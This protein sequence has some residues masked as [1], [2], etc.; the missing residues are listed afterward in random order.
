M[1]KI[2][3]LKLYREN[4]SLFRAGLLFA[5]FATAFMVAITSDYMQDGPI[6]QFSATLSHIAVGI[7]RLWEPVAT[8]TG[9]VVSS[10]RFSIRIVNGCNG[11]EVT[12]LLI[13]AILATPVPWKKRVAGIAIGSALIYVLNLFRIIILFAIGSHYSME[14]FDFFHIYIFQTVVVLI[15]VAFFLGWIGPVSA[16]EK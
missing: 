10:P 8:A 7:I 15:P 12:S 3:T 11:V 1:N 13:A 5:F 4:V 2:S 9:T 6:K 14:V 16:E